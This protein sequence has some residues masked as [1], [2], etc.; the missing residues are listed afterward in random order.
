MRAAV[1]A[2]VD[3]V[4]AGTRLDRIALLHASPEPYARLSH[5]QLAAAGLRTN[6]AAVVPLSARVAGRT[7]LELL[8]LPAGGYRRQDVF[9]WLASAPVL[10]DGRHAPVTAWERLSREAAV[11]AGRSDWDRLLTQLA[12]QSDE[13]RRR[14]GARRRGARVA[15]RARAGRGAPRP[16]SCAPS[17]SA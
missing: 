14:G 5:E 4:R 3:A 15:G 6:G 8:A 13:P 7:L 2:V 12:E 11:V 17:S 9:A 16:A 1:R 10:H